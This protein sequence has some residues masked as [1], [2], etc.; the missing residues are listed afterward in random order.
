MESCVR[1]ERLRFAL[2]CA[3]SPLPF[4]GSF[5]LFPLRVKVKVKGGGWEDLI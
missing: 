2:R 1:F 3:S 4:F 5:R